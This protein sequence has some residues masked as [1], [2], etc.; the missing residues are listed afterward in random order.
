MNVKAMVLAVAAVLVA[1]PLTAQVGHDP[2]RSPYS[3]LEHS[4]EL[5]PFV[6]YMRARTDPA[7]VAPKSAAV[8]GLR[9][10]LTLTGPLAISSEISRASSS[11]SVLDPTKPVLTR[12]L[13]SVSSPVYAADIALALNLTGRKAW[14]RL[15]P[16]LRAGAGL[17]HSAASDDSSGFSFGTPFAFTFGG[18]VK[19]VSAGRLQVRADVTDHVFHLNYPDAYYRL[20]SDNTAVLGSGTAKSFY[21]H[22]TGLTVG[23]SYLFAR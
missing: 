16:Q 5:T 21:T 17:V 22:H 23:V 3:D 13:G 4:Q 12:Q 18:G 6:G 1:L 2:A 20:T 15:V 9:Y 11:R 19:L 7:G 8:V 14:N 10:E